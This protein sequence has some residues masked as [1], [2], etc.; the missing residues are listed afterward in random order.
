MKD[1]NNNQTINSTLLYF[2]PCFRRRIKMPPLVPG[3]PRPPM[4]LES[5]VDF[6]MLQPCKNLGS[7]KVRLTYY[8]PDVS[9][10][11]VMVDGNSY[12][13]TKDD[14]GYWT[15]EFV[16]TPGIHV[17]RYRVDGAVVLNPV[18]PFAFCAGEP[19]N[20]FEVVDD[21]SDFYLIKDVPH[22]DLRME[23]YRSSYTGRWKACWVYTPAGYEQNPEKD[24]PVLYLQHGAGEDETGWLDM[25]KANY[26]LDNLIAEG[27]CA[28]MLVV[29]NCG[30]AIKPGEERT[31]TGGF[32]RYGSSG[33]SLITGVKTQ[34]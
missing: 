2:N 6:K 33:A 22:G 3:A 34:P 20:I 23:Y 28:E 26:I 25:G 32:Q 21:G 14:D 31:M 11:E 27:R 15:V 13:M 18:M 5:P 29:M 12:P 7:G 16:T 17:H 19:A 30:W 1:I 9:A 8:N 24:Y 10:A 4:S